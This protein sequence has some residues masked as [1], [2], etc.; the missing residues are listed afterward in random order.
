MK[1]AKV[2]WSRYLSVHMAL[3]WLVGVVAVA[4]GFQWGRLTTATIWLSL[5]PGL[6]VLVLGLISWRLLVRRLDSLEFP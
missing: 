4:V 6:A 5:I 1:K 3:T 2:S